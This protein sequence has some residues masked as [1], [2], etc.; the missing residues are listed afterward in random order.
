MT[1]PPLTHGVSEE[2]EGIQGPE[3]AKSATAGDCERLKGVRAPAG[4]GVGNKPVSSGGDSSS[5]SK[6]SVSCTVHLSEIH[7][8]IWPPQFTQTSKTYVCT[9]YAE[10]GNFKVH[11]AML[12][13]ETPFTYRAY[14]H[15]ENLDVCMC[16]PFH[17][18]IT[19][20]GSPSLR[21]T[22][23]P[24]GQTCLPRLPSCPS[25]TAPGRTPP[26]AP[27]LPPGLRGASHAALLCPS[28][29]PAQKGRVGGWGRGEE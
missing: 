25:T 15:R 11:N 12:R 24:A 1:A 20:Q 3:C 21:H 14:I 22:A 26:T 19:Y 27:L 18:D 5:S 10:T 6:F 28:Q 17:H 13:R 4:A 9:L 29:T 16:P 2:L 8:Q 23:G 7:T